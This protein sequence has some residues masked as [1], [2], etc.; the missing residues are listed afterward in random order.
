M[1]SLGK[2]GTEYVTDDL[3]CFTPVFVLGFALELGEGVGV[4]VAEGVG[5]GVAEGVGV[6]LELGVGVGDGIDCEIN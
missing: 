4:G 1:F 2:L 3:F 6:G 5:V